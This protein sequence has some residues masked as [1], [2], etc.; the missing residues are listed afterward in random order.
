MRRLFTVKTGQ[1]EYTRTTFVGLVLL[2][3][4]LIE[5]NATISIKIDK[6]KKASR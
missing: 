2:I 5:V 3:K 6:E 4:Q 1:D